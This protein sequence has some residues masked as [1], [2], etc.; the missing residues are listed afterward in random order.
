MATYR[1]HIHNGMVV[2]DDPIDLP[3]GTEVKVDAVNEMEDL[4]GIHPEV[5]AMTGIIPSIDDPKGE[6]YRYLEEKH[7]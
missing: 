5:L 1:G 3:E 4:E 2:L 6:Y 7:L